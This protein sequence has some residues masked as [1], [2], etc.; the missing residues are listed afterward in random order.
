[1][2]RRILTPLCLLLAVAA[3]GA[4]A[5][6]ASLRLPDGSTFESWE[7]PAEHTRTIHVDQGHENTSDDNDGSAEAPLLTIQAAADRLQ[8][9]ERVLIHAGLYRETVRP[10]RGGD[11]PERMITYEA[12]PGEEVVI[13]GAEAYEGPW[14]PQTRWNPG[15]K[16][17]PREGTADG[18]I[19]HLRLPAEWFVGYL[20]FGMVNLPQHHTFYGGEVKNFPDHLRPKLYLK[21]GLI[22][23]D[24]RRLTQVAQPQELDE[25]EGTYWCEDTGLDVQVRPFGDTPEDSTWE[26]TTREQAF[27]PEEKNLDFIRVSG[28]TLRHVADP[29]PMPQRGA[30][31]TS[32]GRHWIIE[33]CRIHDVNAV[34]IDIG[35]EFWSVTGREPQGYAIV[36]GNTIQ[37]AGLMG[38]CGWAPAM[39][40]LLIED[41]LIEGCGWHG[42][43]RLWENAAI[44]LHHVKDSVLRRNL[45]RDTT[46]ASGIWLDFGIS[47]TRVTSN[48]ILN[49]TTGY[50]GVFVEAA[51]QAPVLID[52]NI[53][54]G[55]RQ[56]APLSAAVGAEA[57]NGGHGVYAH[58]TDRMVI[59]H[60]LFFDCEGSGAH[61]ALGQTARIAITGRGAI[62]RDNKVWN[63]VMIGT[64]RYVHFGRPNNFSDGNLFVGKV[65]PSAYVSRFQI[66]EPLENLDW[67]TWREFL[68][69]DLHGQRMGAKPP[70][71]ER[72]GE[73]R[74]RVTLPSAPPMVP[75]L[76]EDLGSDELALG[77]DEARVLPGPFETA[78]AWERPID[79]DPRQRE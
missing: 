75:A 50:G 48:V 32:H 24:G 65:E 40:S 70:T 29:W 34:A 16:Q 74:L 7:R 17:K 62:C 49:T 58:D 79:L 47:N 61:V 5:A 6:E 44:K 64:R 30:L 68:G 39:Q 42:I 52:R 57:V 12:A 4:A 46:D 77:E 25:K 8:P 37:R 20:P 10:R 51:K 18:T 60:N 72:D 67:E 33:D 27:A 11:G 28:L 78:E 38:L 53:V 14:K 66:G 43:E 71:A 35:R 54:I 22:F 3:A 1:M 2:L 41:N 45:I 73:G 23:Q 31:S 26:V 15:W 69:F 76:P 19:Y 56:V 63:N 36:R 13:T 9:G 21:R 55:S 59:A